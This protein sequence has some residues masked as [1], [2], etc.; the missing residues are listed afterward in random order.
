MNRTVVKGEQDEQQISNELNKNIKENFNYNEEFDYD[1]DGALMIILKIKKVIETKL[2]EQIKI[3]SKH[4]NRT[5]LDK[6]LDDWLER[7]NNTLSIFNNEEYKKAMKIEDQLTDYMNS[8]KDPNLE[9]LPECSIELKG[10]IVNE[11]DLYWDK[12]LITGGYR[13]WGKSKTNVKYKNEIL[14]SELIE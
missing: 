6:I 14:N 9:N 1:D 11:F 12:N 10:L 3:L 5:H 8:K 4:A 13:E 7:T 2:Q